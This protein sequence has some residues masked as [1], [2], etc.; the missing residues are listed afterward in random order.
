MS[1]MRLAT[2]AAALLLLGCQQSQPTELDGSIA[3]Y[4]DRML[5]EHAQ[6][7]PAET[8]RRPARAPVAVPVTWQE[9]LGPREALLVQPQVDYV[10]RPTEVLFE[11]PDPAE[12]R[13]VF[14]VRLE[15]LRDDQA[16]RRDQRIVQMFE[17]VVQKSEEYLQKLDRP[18]TARPLSLAECLLR[19]LEHNYGIRIE[20]YTPAISQTQIVEAEARFDVEF[21]LDTAYA[22]RDQPTA[23]TFAAGQA[24]T[25]SIEAGF[26]QLLPTGAQASVALGQARSSTNLPAQFQSMNPTYDTT[27]TAQLRQPLMRGFGLDLNRAQIEIARRDY[28]VS[29]EQFIQRV[30]DTLFE[31][32]QAY[33]Q[34]AQ[35]RRRVSILAE[36]VAQNFVTKENMVERLPHDATEVEVQ[37]ATSSWRTSEVQFLEAV[38]LVKDAEDRLKNLMNDPELTLAADIELLPTEVPYVSPMLLD[39]FAEVRTAIDER[40]EIRQARERIE[41]ARIST[42]AA[43]NA[44]L[45]QLDLNF[46]YQVQGMGGTADNSFDNLTTNRFISYSVGVQFAY[47][48]GE[49]RARAA[50]QRARHQ[51]AQSVVALNQIVDFIVEEVNQSVRTLTV[52]YS[53]L[54][55]ALGSVQAAVANLRALQAR[56]AQLD[57]NYLQTELTAVE[58]LAARRSTLLQVMIEYNIALVQLEKAKGTLLHYNNVTVVDGQKS[59]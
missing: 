2:V 35:A 51:E 25:R 28:N 9:A 30:R 47:N 6:H 15:R 49:R 57:P 39:H 5:S 58:N 41:Q 55:P 44:I 32:E 46:T 12:A 34:L 18:G 7:A 33:W 1:W 22:L 16:G 3:A 53:Q 23:Q 4:R 36:T 21:Y 54:P 14:R 11:L 29:R 38:K 8:A 27:F 37:N 26:R 24:D 56:T 59:R 13:E 10:P 42:S 20:A 31:A 40:S 19:T 50:H 52:R 48:F 17:R 43:K 45:P